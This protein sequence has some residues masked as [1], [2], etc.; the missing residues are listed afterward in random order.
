MRFLETRSEKPGKIANSGSA[1]QLKPDFLPILS[2]L[3][4]LY[5]APLLHLNVPSL[6]TI[7]AGLS[8][9]LDTITNRAKR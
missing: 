3:S 5:Y 9:R 2:L 4:H 6:K 8:T 1:M 7:E